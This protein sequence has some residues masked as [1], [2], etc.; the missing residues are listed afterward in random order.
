MGRP[1]TVG[2]DGVKRVAAYQLVGHHL[3][4]PRAVEGL[5]AHH[6]AVNCEHRPHLVCR[7]PERPDVLV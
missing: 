6:L 3:V 1:F 2:S 7:N 5:K 4:R